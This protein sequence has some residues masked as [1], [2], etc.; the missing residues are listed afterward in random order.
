MWLFTDKFER[1]RAVFAEIK[2]QERQA[3]DRSAA[4]ARLVAVGRGADYGYRPHPLHGLSRLM[5][6][7]LAIF[8][9]DG[10]LADS[11]PW[12]RAHVNEW[13]TVSASAASRRRISGAAPRRPARGSG[14][15]SAVPLWK[16]PRSPG[17]C[18]GS[19]QEHLDAIPL[20]PGVDAML[21]A[22]REGA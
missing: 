5:R 22:L 2:A 16:V 4:G 13:R 6:Y 3:G 14:A 11:L 18:G 15:P 1:A 7:R 8:D 17:T 21:R 19:R 9:L 12:F 10:T 20:F